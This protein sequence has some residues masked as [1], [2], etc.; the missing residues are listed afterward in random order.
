MRKR[1]VSPSVKKKE[2]MGLFRTVL[3][4]VSVSFGA[5]VQP[6]FCVAASPE[7]FTNTT[8]LDWYSWPL[9]FPR[10]WKPWQNTPASASS[11]VTV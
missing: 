7:A 1:T 11:F 4:T 3:V 6:F 10:T 5:A 8:V 9:S 2:F